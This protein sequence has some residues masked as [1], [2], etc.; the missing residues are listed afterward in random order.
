[1]AEKVLVITATNRLMSQKLRT[2]THMMKKKQEIKN[3]ESIMEYISGDHYQS[4]TQHYNR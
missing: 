2:T 3:S 4:V 1:M